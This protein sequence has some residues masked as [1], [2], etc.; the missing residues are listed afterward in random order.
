MQ[1]SVEEFIIISPWSKFLSLVTFTSAFPG[2]SYLFYLFIIMGW[3]RYRFLEGGNSLHL[4]PN[5]GITYGEMFKIND[6]YSINRLP[7][8]NFT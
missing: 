1:L 8:R 4:L 6:I 3:V 2:R 7:N 5:A